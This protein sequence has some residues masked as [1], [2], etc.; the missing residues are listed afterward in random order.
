MKTFL[1][2]IILFWATPVWSCGFVPLKPLTPL[3]CSDLIA[4]CVCDEDGQN[5][6]YQWQC[7]R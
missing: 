3:G 5:C 2:L 1:F 6:Y 4:V 7:V